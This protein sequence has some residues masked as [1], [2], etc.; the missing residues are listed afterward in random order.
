MQ[1]I[2]IIPANQDFPYTWVL[3][4]VSFGLGK[5]GIMKKV[6]RKTEFNPETGKHSKQ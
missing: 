4:K 3:G 1:I 6:L 2:S 5:S